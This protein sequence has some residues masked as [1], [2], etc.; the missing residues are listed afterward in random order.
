MAIKYHY[1]IEQGT[2]E[3][4]AK[5]MGIVTASNIN[6]LL[7][8]KGK[9]AKGAKILD[10]AC[11]LVAERETKRVEDNF[12]SYKMITGH[13]REVMARDIYSESYAE[14]K[15]CGFV[16]NDDAGYV[17]GASPD[18][19]VGEDGGVEIK[20]RDQKFQIRTIYNGEVPDEYMNQI[21]T[22]LMVTGRKW[23]EFVSFS[24][25]MPLFV[26]RVFPDFERQAEIRLAVEAFY[27]VVEGVMA[28][29]DSKAESLVKTEYV[30][31]E[32]DDEIS[33]SEA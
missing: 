9:P 13:I 26:K 8:P 25:G 15:E 28:S 11:N 6:I 16:T 18:G 4:H 12:Q 5:R 7:T 32:I 1:D 24:N 30:E 33:E 21:Q 31:I 17:L 20:S 29:Y 10:Y 14:V 23:W 2:D 27:G 3:W 19:L 22:C